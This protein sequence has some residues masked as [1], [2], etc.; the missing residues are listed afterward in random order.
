MAAT[1]SR[2]RLAPIRFGGQ[3]PSSRLNPKPKLLEKPDQHI[4]LKCARSMSTETD[5][6]AFQGLYQVELPK[7]LQIVRF[8]PIQSIVIQYFKRPKTFR[9]VICDSRMCE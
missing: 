8:V 1:G 3:T 9:P 5:H 2:S 4:K 6:L 7:I